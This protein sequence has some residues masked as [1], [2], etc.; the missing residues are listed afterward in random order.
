[1]PTHHRRSVDNPFANR[2]NRTVGYSDHRYGNPH[3]HNQQN[4]S[5]KGCLRSPLTCF[6]ITLGCISFLILPPSNLDDQSLYKNADLE[7]EKPTKQQ[8]VPKE[9]TEFEINNDDTAIDGNFEKSNHSL[10]NSSTKEVSIDETKNDVKKK[11]VIE[12]FDFEKEYF[13]DRENNF[14]EEEYK[15]HGESSGD[16]DTVGKSQPREIFHI[17]ESQNNENAGHAIIDS[18]FHK[19][20]LTEQESNAF[21]DVFNLGG[22]SEPH[23]RHKIEEFQTHKKSEVMKINNTVY[24]TKLGGA[25]KLNKSY[26]EGLSTDK[27]ELEY[28]EL[29]T[30]KDTD[31]V[32]N[33]DERGDGNRDEKREHEEE[34][35]DEKAFVEDAVRRFSNLDE[36][37]KLEEKNFTN[38]TSDNFARGN[39]LVNVT[40]I[41]GSLALT[42]LNPDQTL[43]SKPMHANN[44]V[45]S[46]DEPTREN[47]TNQNFTASTNSSNVADAKSV[48]FSEEGF[49]D[50]DE[51]RSKELMNTRVVDIVLASENIT[52]IIV[53][54]TQI[55]SNSTTGEK[56]ENVE[57]KTKFSSTT[58][59]IEIISENEIVDEN[60]ITN[61][62]SELTGEVIPET[63]ESVASSS[64]TS[65]TARVFDDIVPST[66]FDNV[67]K[68][69]VK[70]IKTNHMGINGASNADGNSLAT[71]VNNTESGKTNNLTV[72]TE[73]VKLENITN[74]T[75]SATSQNHQNTTGNLRG[76]TVD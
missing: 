41:S 39:P 48:N 19:K 40:N 38:T 35:D 17:D 9:L 7:R 33:V 1:M 52:T 21:V 54:E 26:D 31:S 37:Y 75:T 60:P 2:S 72:S 46:N 62:N 15:D 43:P 44:N 13:F 74:A 58:A 34:V 49:E 64:N 36:N 5:R 10:Q 14:I 30:T 65:N 56:S 3:H 23:E 68:A 25:T 8:S 29:L 69:D 71:A 42:P 66:N 50:A 32:T 61:R 47:V 16:F 57:D 24:Q 11:D 67:T 59:F 27:I 73:S 55:D 51:D 6:I 22:E 63:L 12:N 4:R 45:T 18:E 53:N 76:F 70:K 28:S 20:N